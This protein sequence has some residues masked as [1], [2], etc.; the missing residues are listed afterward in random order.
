MG[1]SMSSAA[2]LA[3]LRRELRADKIRQLEK[4]QLQMQMEQKLSVLALQ[5]QMDLMKAD[6]DRKELQRQ[7]ELERSERKA[8]EERTKQYVAMREVPGQRLVQ[9]L[10]RSSR[11]ARGGAELLAAGQCVDGS[12]AM[13]E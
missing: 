13:P 11:V 4:T 2:E 7:L 5:R 8:V 3:A 9:Q 12:A 6:L 1:I 10:G